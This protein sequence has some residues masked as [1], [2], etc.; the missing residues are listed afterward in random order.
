MIAPALSAVST[1]AGQ[2]D[3]PSDGHAEPPSRGQLDYLV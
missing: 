1:D 2:P 3:L